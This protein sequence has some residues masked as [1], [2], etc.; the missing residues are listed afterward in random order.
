MSANTALET[1]FCS[2][3]NLSSLDVSSNTAL[4][5]LRC[6][7]NNLSNLDVSANTALMLLWCSNNNLSSIDVSANTALTYL[8]CSSNNLSNLDV[9]ANTALS[10]LYCHFNNLSSLDVS[11]NT[12]LTK[13]SCNDN[14][15]SSLDVSVNTALTFLKCT[16]NNLSSLDVTANTALSTLWCSYNNLSSL[17]IRNGNN[18]AISTVSFGASNNP[19]LFCIN[20]DDVAY[21]TTNWINID[22]WANFNTNCE[23]LTYVPDDN[24]EA[25]LEANGMG[26]GIANDDHV[27]TASIS[28]VTSLTVNSLSIADLTGIEDFTALESL[29]CA[30]NI[31]NTI[32]VSQNTS[33]TSLDCSNNQLSSLN[34][35]QNTNLQNLT[36]DNNL[37][38]SL[39]LT[40]NTALAVL[41]CSVNQLTSLY[42]TQNTALQIIDCRT[43]QLSVLN[44][45]NGNNLNVLFFNSS[46]NPDLSCIEVDD[47]A[48]STANWT[49]DPAS[50]FSEDCGVKIWENAAWTG[51]IPS[52]SEHAIIRDDYNTN[53]Q[54]ANIEANS[55]I[56]D[57]NFTVTVTSGDYLFTKGNITVNGSLIVNHEGSVVQLADA[58]TVTNNG[59]IQVIKTTP[60]ATGNSFSILGSPMSGTTRDGTFADNNVV[61]SHDTNLFNLD[62]DV[63]A[64]ILGGAEHFA[65]AEGDN[66]L[67]LTGSENINPTQGYLVGPTTQ[68]VNDGFYILNYNQGTLNNGVYIFN[69][70]FNNVGTPAENKSNSPNILS[71]PYASAI[72]ADMLISN[73]SV[74]D[75]LYFWEHLTPPNSSYPG[76]RAENW[77]MGDISMRNLGAG[78]PAANGGAAPTQY[79]ASGQGFG[80]KANAQATVTFNNALRV[81]GNNTGYRNAE[82]ERLYVNIKNET[83]GLRSSTAIAF[84]SAATQGFDPMY[85]SNR[86]ATPISIYSVLE[87]KELAIQGRPAFNTDQII[88]L[89]FRTMVEEEQTYTI[90]LGTIEGENITEAT[91][92]LEDHL[93]HTV[94]NLNESDYTF[95]SNEGNQKDRFVIVF[96]EEQLG[97]TEASLEAISMYPNPTANILN[98][99]SPQANIT[100]VTLFDLQGRIISENKMDNQSR[101]QLDMSELANAVY[102]VRITSQYGSITKQIIKK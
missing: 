89:G 44:V 36:C 101:F 42:L 94:T 90:S 50:S 21:S 91:V 74:I 7:Y 29:S 51:G 102:M 47:A 82:I 17:D 55:L 96:S 56:I 58:A 34:V 49:K 40:N 13:L 9:S 30:N 61:M 41:D 71:N 6:Y 48:Y 4:E 99:V 68:S 26:N 59:N 15:L 5:T 86:L 72:D 88:P 53:I 75:E 76:Y 93:L 92:Y 80:I 45:K 39:S 14:N 77:D 52:L 97:N 98:I 20:V 2:Y 24:F 23:D 83:Y 73:N 85:D 16:N 100:N 78:I 8:N 81:T 28:G 25:Y 22:P 19:N 60:V 64:V 32:N 3:N 27:L 33:L 65:D 66:W 43:N 87:E 62:P 84:T 12:A 54:G 1:L 31:L 63:T 35:A 79:I 18:M 70:V 11:A 69:T 46:S 37:L 67:F 57:P 38:T 95:T 10:T